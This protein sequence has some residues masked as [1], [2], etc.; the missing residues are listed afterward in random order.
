MH[1]HRREDEAIFVL[2]G[3]VTFRSDGTEETLGPGG[4]ALLPAGTNHQFVNDNDSAVSLLI[5]V[6]PA[7]L[8]AMFQKTGLPWSDPTTLPGTLGKEEIDRMI[9]AAPEFG[10][11]LHP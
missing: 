11:E 9:A 3:N 2:A 7:G 4:F 1:T 8:E 6:A 10:L 5:V